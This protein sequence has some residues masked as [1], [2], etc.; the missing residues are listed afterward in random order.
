MLKSLKSLFGAKEKE[1]EKILAPVE[2][3]AIPVTEVPDPTFAEEMLGKGAAIHPAKGRVVAP[4]DGQVVVMFPTG[5]AVSIR[6]SEGAE[7][8][9]HV[10]L[11][12]VNLEG[13][14]FTTHVKEGDTVKAGDLLVEFDKEAIEAAGYKMITPV[15]ICNSD[16][17]AEVKKHS[18]AV[19]E[20]DVLLELKR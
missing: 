6:T 14:Y 18:G 10:G 15:V 19:K 1:A 9:I 7:I 11:D 17:Y 20:G 12:T 16:E 4:A 3:E 2:G 8:L 13:K 5:H